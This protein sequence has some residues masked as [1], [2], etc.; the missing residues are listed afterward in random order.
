MKRG[1][2]F[3]MLVVVTTFYSTAQINLGSGTA[4]NHNL[5]F[6]SAKEYSYSQFIYHASDI[7]N[8]GAITGIKLYKG[9][10]DLANADDWDVYIGTTALNGFFTNSSWVNANALTQVFSGAVAQNSLGEIEI[11]FSTPFIYNGLDNI[12]VAIDEN[13]P[14]SLSPGNAFYG[15]TYSGNRGILF[16]ENGIANNPSPLN[17]PPAAVANGG[18]KNTIPNITFLGLTNNC[19]IPKSVIY[20]QTFDSYIPNCWQEK[21]GVLTSSGVNFTNTTTSDWAGYA[22]GGIGTSTDQALINMSSTF[23]QEW[24]ISPSFDLGT[25][26]HL[27]SFDLGMEA[28]GGSPTPI[29]LDADDS[30]SVVI[31]LDNG[32]TWLP[33]N[34]IHTITAG[35][36]PLETGTSYTIDL[37][38]YSGVVKFAFYAR[39]TAYITPKAVWLDNFFIEPSSSCVKPLNLSSSAITATTATLNWTGSAANYQVSYGMNGTQPGN[40]TLTLTSGTS[41]NLSGL[42]AGTTYELYVRSICNAG[43]TSVW[44]DPILFTT[45][46]GPSIIPSYSQNFDNYLPNCWEEKQGTLGTVNTT[47]SASNSSLW[48]QED[49]AKMGI[50]DAASMALQV[51]S[52]RRE[53]WLI[54]PTF[55]LGTTNNLQV[56]F[57]V[58]L[59]A[60]SDTSS[61]LFDSDDTL[62]FV[63]STDNGVTWNTSNIIETWDDA[64]MP[65]NLGTFVHYDLSTYSGLVKF[66]FYVASSTTTGFIAKKV[67][68]DNFK[69]IA[70]PT[71]NQPESYTITNV[72]SNSV[73]IDWAPTTVSNL[74]I[75][76]G[77]TG[78]IPGSGSVIITTAAPYT[79][80]NLMPETTYDIYLQSICAAG[81]T[82]VQTSLRNFTTACGTVT[83]SYY[84]N[85]ATYLP[86]CWEE[87]RGKL[88][89]VNTVF[90]NVGFS[91]WTQDGFANV[92]TTGSARMQLSSTSLREWLIS[93]TFDLGVSNTFD[94]TFDIA[95]TGYAGGGATTASLG[96][97]DTI[98]VIISTDNGVT[99][100]QGDILQIWEDGTEPSLTGEAITIDLSSY[101]GL[102]KIGFYVAKSASSNNNKVF[103]D[104]FRIANASTC[105]V[106]SALSVSNITHNTADI[107]WTTG[108]AANALI[109]YG[110]DGFL[111]GPGFT[112]L[113]S[114]S[115]VTLTGLDNL[116]N[117][118]V[119]VRDI[120]A[121]GDTSYYSQVLSFATEC[122][123]F[124]PTY[125]Q[126]F[127]SYIP[128][129]WTEER[130]RLGATATNFSSSGL[131]SWGV[132]G[133][134]NITNVG[135][136][137]V[138]MSQ[139][140]A[141]EWLLTPSIDLGAGTINYLAEFKVAFSNNSNSLPASMDA[142]DTLAFVIST[143]N[144][145]TWSQANILKTWGIG[146]EPSNTGNYF[147]ADLSSYSG[148]VKFGFYAAS[149]TGSLAPAA[150]IDD[151]RILPTPSCVT[152]YDIQ[153]TNLVANS[154]DIGWTSTATNAQIEYG[155]AGFLPGTG[156][157][158]TTGNNPYTLTGLVDQTD[159]DFYVRTICTAGD[160]SNWTLLNTVTTPCPI[161]SAPYFEGF[162]PYPANC[163]SEAQGNFVM[164]Y[165]IYLIIVA[166]HG[167]KTV[168]EMLALVVLP[169]WSFG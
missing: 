98:A 62:A 12:V 36:E 58:A 157:L 100:A 74:K 72:S 91:N 65:S 126:N 77:P 159:Y 92:S 167:H 94:L 96:S 21:E 28:V 113:A 115:P 76:Y 57:E 161:F 33:S 26:A 11:I 37:S 144:G 125:S 29:I 60:W 64:S 23:K 55:D 106:P 24:L 102:V 30:I 136:A 20:T 132:G 146:N 107:S 17:P 5:P 86:Q 142:D 169:K 16:A 43:D 10:A 42:S 143:D 67:F 46:C 75:E 47:F 51:T 78:I 66:G 103:I 158:V 54:S 110:P 3:L 123:L 52:N 149:S 150:F 80:N 114:S 97:T 34:I 120:C 61:V 2:V 89:A 118:Q 85:F 162:D 121:V 104:N 116:T 117:Y 19:N 152:P 95:L 133:F 119:Y 68:V 101:S 49:F 41:S 164:V 15:T 145:I 163:W 154:V 6:S 148:L 151:F 9:G 63:I 56:E 93:P 31:S 166:P 35:S 73:D 38:P 139:T 124:Y 109:E 32:A 84:Q 147:A 39:S 88:G 137:K 127:T 155:P 53:E 25:S 160:T 108:G 129:C 105:S 44:S 128:E 48:T 156:T 45:N 13:A 135:A 99:W 4:T 131:A 69:I 18:L 22:S 71:C 59:T 70:S 79:L 1:V 138:T 112:V 134:G 87:K 130:G 81:D 83:P 165:L 153:L 141:M 50:S 7:N 82:S 168:L 111:L 8:S 90:E 14:G 40:G 27:L 140:T 122:P